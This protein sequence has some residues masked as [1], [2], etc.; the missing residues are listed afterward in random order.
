MPAEMID[1]LQA[2]VEFTEFD[3]VDEYV[4]FVLEEVLLAVES[5]EES[6]NVREEDVKSRLKSLGYIE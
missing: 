1:R 3:T 5:D 2:R 6:D 4:Q